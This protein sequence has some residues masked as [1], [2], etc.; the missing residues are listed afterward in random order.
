[1]P[2][3]FA[4]GQQTPG[5][6]EL[7]IP[8]EDG[9]WYSARSVQEEFQRKLRTPPKANPADD[10]RW[11]LTAADRAALILAKQ[12]GL[13]DVRFETDRLVLVISD[14][15]DDVVRRERRER[16][17]RWLNVEQDQWPEGKGLQIPDRL[18]PAKQ[19]M[20]LVHGLFSI[21]GDLDRLQ[22]ACDAAGLQTL[23]FNYPNDGPVAWSGDLL[24]NDL[25]RFAKQHPNVKLA[26]IAH[27]MGGL[28]VRHALEAG[29][30]N[31][32]GISDVFFLGTPHQGSALAIDSEPLKLIF[33]PVLPKSSLIHDLQNGL[34]EA[35]VD[36]TP[37]SRFLSDLNSRRRPDEIQY[38][39]AIGTK[40]FFTKE[41]YQALITVARRWAND[42][43]H[44]IDS[45]LGILQILESDE[46]KPGG[47]D[48]AVSINSAR[49][50]DASTFKR[51]DLNHL[52]LKDL[53]GQKPE[54][55]EVFQWILQTLNP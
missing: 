1:M 46:M 47:G 53:P 26:I 24:R 49:S 18:E 31:F 11:E 16:L 52:E 32:P 20:L 21:Q 14:E 5:S 38:H 33:S 15:E 9:R 8:L 39:V 55:A 43:E 13:I 44:P 29:D 3:F 34:G 40:S 10:R 4:C 22:S 25:Q 48:G 28:V 23:T 54:T 6:I 2:I 7:I 41:Q 19:T 45:R 27:S 51:F 35:R 12:A 17:A 42:S 30:A 50:I 36:L 37:G